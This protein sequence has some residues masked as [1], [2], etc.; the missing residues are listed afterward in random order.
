MS[1][2]YAMEALRLST[3]EL[4]RD[5]PRALHAV[6]ALA[7]VYRSLSEPAKELS[8]LQHVQQ[9]LGVDEAK[10]LSE[11]SKAVDIAKLLPWKLSDHRP[12]A[13]GLDFCAAALQ[14]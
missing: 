10:E 7:L 4:G 2:R 8:A 1:A 5:H 3:I 6:Q 14:V 12:P 13:T 9:H 11:L